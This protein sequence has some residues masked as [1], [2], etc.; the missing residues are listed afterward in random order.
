MPYPP[1]IPEPGQRLFRVE[2]MPHR[3]P[4][5]PD[6]LMA[7]E[8]EFVG[9]AKG[10]RKMLLIWLDAVRR[11]PSPWPKDPKRP[12]F[13]TQREAIDGRRKKYEMGVRLAQ[14]TLSAC[15]QE[16]TGFN[17]TFPETED[18]PE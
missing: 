14:G 11:E 10:Q 12:F 2:W 4:A 15:Q 3:D 18:T 7:C 5:K 8:F 16:L 9:M 13:A 17:N 6:I 1:D